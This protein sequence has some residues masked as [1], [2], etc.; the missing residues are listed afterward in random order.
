L[1]SE[2]ADAGPIE[3]RG[4][5]PADADTV[6]RL[7]YETATGMYDIYA[8]GADRALRILRAAYAKPGNSASRETIRVA[9]IG[10]EVAGALAAFPVP[11]GDRRASRFL[12]VTIVRTPPWKWPATLRIF[13]TGAD[14]TPV[15]PPNSLYIDA[16]ATDGRF[17]RRGVASAL[18]D[19]ASRVASAAGLGMVA[20]D[21]AVTNAGAQALYERAGFRVTERRPP[22]GRIPGIVGYARPTR[23]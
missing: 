10:G 23:T 4:A 14:L 19:E 21:T 13:Q 17:R 16:L 9:T 20:L 3:I 5:E 12:R 18:L 6:A 11:E 15:P 8:G 7:L 1:G 22:K 2:P